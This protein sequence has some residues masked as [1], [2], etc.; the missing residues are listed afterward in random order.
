[1][2]EEFRLRSVAVAAYGPATLFGLAEGAMLPVIT[3]SV[4]DRGASTSIA[5]LIGA[6]LG[7]GSIVTNIPSGILATRIGERKSMLVA[8]VATVAGLALCL[9][10][11]GHGAGSLLIYGLGVLLIGAASSV[12]GL[13][14]QSYLTEMVPPRMR[15]R[16][17]STLGGTLRIG[18]FLGPFLGAGAMELWG[19]PGAYYVSLT[20]I[21]AAG[22]IVYRVPDLEMSDQH[23]AAAAQVTSWGVLKRYWRTFVTLGTGVLLLSAIR[24]TRQVVIPLWATHIGLSPTANSIIYGVAGAVDAL[25]FYPAG[26]VMDEYGRRWVAVPCVVIMGISFVLMPLT[27]GPV[28]LALTAMLMGFGNGIGSGIVNTLAADTS[29][30]I[31]RPTF[32]GIWRELADAGSGVGPVILSAVTALAGLA[33]GIIV[34]GMVGFAAAAALWAWIPKRPGRNSL[35]SPSRRGLRPALV[36]FRGTSIAAMT[37]LAGKTAVVTGGSRGIGRA[38]VRRLAADGARVVFSFRADKAAADALAREIGDAVAVQADQEDLENLDVLFEPVADG[39]DILVNNAAITA[40][41][42][43]SEITPE[44]FDQAMTVNA[45]FPL[46]AM[47]RAAPL[48]RDGGRIISIST[49]NTAAPGPGIALYCA[50]KAALEQFTRVAAYELG[51]RGITANI[52]SPGATDTELLRAS[53]SPESLERAAAL[54]AL[55]RLGAPADIADVVAFLASPD[56][57]WITGQNIQATGGLTA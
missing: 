42:P 12:Y 21:V 33:C 50:S 46:L 7:I 4:I 30:A 54:T 40:I 1:M 8:A 25:T 36:A 29:P 44:L 26:K 53:N 22:V 35:A 28:T 38:I 57:R 5:A 39:L 10:D 47:R 45:K 6:L 24:Q 27:H 14:R 9:V 13:A 3:L 20:A 43:I 23:K 16:A 51:P 55:G 49:L 2:S 17:L 34:S 52:V 48:L 31:G 11:L 15:A 32:L 19:L 18:V 56:A 41:A 37:T